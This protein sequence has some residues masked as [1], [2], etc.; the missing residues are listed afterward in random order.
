MIY[1][2]KEKKYIEIEKFNRSICEKE[3]SLAL[4]VNRFER[5]NGSLEELRDGLQSL[6]EMIL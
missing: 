5:M 6:S 3:I 4:D 2:C 1:E